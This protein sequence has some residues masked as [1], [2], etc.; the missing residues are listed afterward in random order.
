MNSTKN[1]QVVNWE[2]EMQKCNTSPYYFYTNYIVVETPEGP[3]KA[4][5]CLTE[6]E[7]NKQF[8]KLNKI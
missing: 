1:I 4:T 3:K 5:T 2:E 6:E 8:N 7:F